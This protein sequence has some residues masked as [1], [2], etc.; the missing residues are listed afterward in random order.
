M[1]SWNATCM[2]TNLPILAGDPVVAQIIVAEPFS[3]PLKSAADSNYPHDRF[4]PVG[5]P[6]RAKYNDYGYIDDIEQSVYADDTLDYLRKHLIERPLGENKYHDHE[7]TKDKLSWNSLDR[8]FHGKRVL[9]TNPISFGGKEYAKQRSVGLVMIH[10]SVYKAMAAYR[11]DWRPYDPEEAI[12]EALT[13]PRDRGLDFIARD[14]LR[15]YTREHEMN[16]P[17]DLIDNGADPGETTRRLAEMAHF[18]IALN[19]S[20]RQWIPTSGAGAQSEEWDLFRRIA[21]VGEMIIE[22]R[23]EE[24]K[25]DDEE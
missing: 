10:A 20:R 14:K 21:E 25:E 11:E 12:R 18:D 17:F 15:R 3:D 13:M 6:L 5:W 19:L 1:G 7:V 4:V 9:L 2:V 22:K 23:E 24:L 8:W 16:S